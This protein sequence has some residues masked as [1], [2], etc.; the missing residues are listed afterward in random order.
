MFFG[1]KNNNTA[2]FPNPNSPLLRMTSYK[3]LAAIALAIVV[4]TAVNAFTATKCCHNRLASCSSS[5]SLSPLFSTV[6]AQQEQH[7][8]TQQLVLPPWI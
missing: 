4:G 7:H 1:H 5:S 2:S 8:S 6:E 3:Q